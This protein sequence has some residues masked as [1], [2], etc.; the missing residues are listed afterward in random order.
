M[1]KTLEMKQRNRNSKQ[2][3]IASKETHTDLKKR[4]EKTDLQSTGSRAA[5]SCWTS[6]SPPDF[7]DRV[8]LV[9]GFVRWLKRTYLAKKRWEYVGLLR[10]GLETEMGFA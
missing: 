4:K 2:I 10:Q 3:K 1:T 9:G 5:I 7:V 8:G 6:S